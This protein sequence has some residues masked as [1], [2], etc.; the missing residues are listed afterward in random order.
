MM[1]RR[2]LILTAAAALTLAS[3][4]TAFA[5]WQQ[6]GDGRY[7]YTY[8][9]GS[10]AKNGVKT[11][12][13]CEYAFDENGYMLTGWQYLNFHWYYFEPT[14]GA[15]VYGWRAIDGK[16]YYFDPD[17]FGEMY[18][19]WLNIGDNRYYLDENGVMQTGIF[20][21]SDP[22]KG[23]SF[24]Y[25]ADPSG[26]LYRNRKIESS[27]GQKTFRYDSDGVMQYSS[28]AT[29]KVAKLTG[30]DEWQY[31]LNEQGQRE[32]D[33]ENDQI[34]LDGVNE[35]KNDLY[36]EY[37]DNAYSKSGNSLQNY[38]DRWESKV[39]RKLKD[40]VDANDLS[41]YISRVE[42][43]RYIRASVSSEYDYDDED[44]YD[45]DYDY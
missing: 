35:I 5:G 13:G 31:V 27:D 25:Q 12:D 6:G 34:I 39:T 20:F 37:R 17:N 36:D 18:T 32:Q 4:S 41:D 19:Y 26:V 43:G 44:D 42:S 7:W 33:A 21:L 1:R 45:E 29:R 16:W 30:D 14:T 2:T 10:C 24:A 28:P 15:K 38:R 40:L 23:S 3:A 9:D 22:T 11:I 8:D